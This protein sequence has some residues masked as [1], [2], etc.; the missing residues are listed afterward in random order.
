MAGLVPAIHVFAEDGNSASLAPM[1]GGW[2]YIVTNAPDGTLYTGVTSDIARRAFEHRE[3]RIDGFTRRYGLKRLVL[4]EFYEDIRDAIQRESNIKHWPRAW[5][6]RLIHAANPDW[7]DLYED[8]NARF[9]EKDVDGRD[10]P[11]HDG[12]WRS[13][14]LA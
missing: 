2:V 11:G 10:K 3:G 4:T 6:V 13:A 7:R 1:R 5:K 8:L 14:H 9:A 12:G